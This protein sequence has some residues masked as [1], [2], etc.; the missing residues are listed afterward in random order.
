[1]GAHLDP[2]APQPGADLEPGAAVGERV[3]PLLVHERDRDDE[4]GLAVAVMV[5]VADLPQVQLR[6]P[7]AGILAGVDKVVV[8]DAV[9]ER[10]GGLRQPPFEHPSPVGWVSQSGWVLTGR[11]WGPVQ[12]DQPVTAADTPKVVAGRPVTLDPGEQ[13]LGPRTEPRNTTGLSNLH[14]V[15]GAGEHER[16]PLPGIGC[17][18]LVAG[19]ALGGFAAHARYAELP[20]DPERAVALA[21]AVTQA[22]RRLESVAAGRQVQRHRQVASAGE[23]IRRERLPDALQRTSAAGQ[24][25]YLT[26]DA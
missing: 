14:Q 6:P 24:G 9:T 11:S 25:Q 1:V 18:V 26:C 7:A 10:I 20:A 13:A 17:P 5:D 22:Q 23:Q 8:F 15:L 21:A 3:G 16:V 2:P 12:A 19:H 4:T